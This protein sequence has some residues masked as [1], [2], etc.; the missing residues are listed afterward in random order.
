[1]AKEKKKADKKG[2]KSAYS[3]SS[4]S[5]YP[6][7]SKQDGNTARQE[8]SP[9]IV[10]LLELP[11]NKL[12]PKRVSRDD[13]QLNKDVTEYEEPILTKLI[14]ERWAYWAALSTVPFLL[15]SLSLSL[16]PCTSPSSCCSFATTPL[17]DCKTN[18][19][20]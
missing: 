3:P 15:S 12:E 20:L 10:P 16:S 14:V 1:M 13:N 19:C 7:F 5:D 2:D 6:E 9:S 11:L 18:L 17:D 8:V 4:L